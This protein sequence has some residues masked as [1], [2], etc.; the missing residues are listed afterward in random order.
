MLL[1]ITQLE[2]RTKSPVLRSKDAVKSASK[3]LG[4]G[5]AAS[6]RL[7]VRLLEIFRLATQVFNAL[8]LLSPLCC[9][10]HELRPTLVFTSVDGRFFFLP[11]ARTHTKR[12]THAHTQLS[13][14]PFFFIAGPLSVGAHYSL[15]DWK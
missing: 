6:L 11:Q 3:C 8:L 4:G 5:G 7:L 12:R 9:R 15:A 1:T 13:P 10:I 2:A 14:P